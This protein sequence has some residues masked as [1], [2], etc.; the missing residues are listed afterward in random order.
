MLHLLKKLHLS[1]IFA[2]LGCCHQAMVKAGA[3]TTA[4]LVECGKHWGILDSVEHACASL[5]AAACVPAH[6]EPHRIP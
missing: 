6:Q 4:G 2:L 3:R 5:D 1:R